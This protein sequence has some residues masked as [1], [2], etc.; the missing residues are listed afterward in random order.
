MCPDPRAQGTI[1]QQ[2]H[3]AQEYVVYMWKMRLPEP[4]IM[5]PNGTWNLEGQYNDRTR[6]PKY[7]RTATCIQSHTNGA[8]GSSKDRH[9]RKADSSKGNIT[10]IRSSSY[11]VKVTAR[12]QLPYLHLM[13]AHSSI[14]PKTPS[15]SSSAGARPLKSTS[16][17]RFCRDARSV[18]PIRTS[19]SSDT[20]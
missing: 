9:T 8:A 4:G 11:I 3:N 12:Q 15:S 17:L 14:R 13:M 10:K 18:S 19:R 1:K 6:G 2:K 5:I 16:A 20:L 7:A